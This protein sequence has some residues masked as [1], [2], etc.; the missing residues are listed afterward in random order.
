[1]LEEAVRPPGQVNGA[2][3]AASDFAQDFVVPEAASLHA[4]RVGSKLDRRGDGPVK[5]ADSAPVSVQHA[6]HL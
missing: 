2:H 4:A 3:A 5:E 6:L 1:M